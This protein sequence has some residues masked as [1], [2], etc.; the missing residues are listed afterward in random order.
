MSNLTFV[1]VTGELGRPFH[2]KKMKVTSWFLALDSA[3]PP[4]TP[5]NTNDLCRCAKPDLSRSDPVTPDLVSPHVT[6]CRNARRPKV[7]DCCLACL[8]SS[9]F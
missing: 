1:F 4:L 7:L 8:N 2:Q 5:P 3:A 9:S 6:V